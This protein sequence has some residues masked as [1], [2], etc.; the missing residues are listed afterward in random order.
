MSFR[1]VWLMGLAACI[2]GSAFAQEVT[3][4]QPAPAPANATPVS[5][6]PAAK[7]DEPVAATDPNPAKA[8]EEGKLDADKI[9]AAQKAGYQ[10]KNEN[11][12]TLLCRKELQTGSRVR[13]RTSCLTAREWDQL[14]KDTVQTMRTFERPKP[15]IGNH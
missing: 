11:G 3:P 7:A 1:S 8:L 6:A 10:L 14:Q 9:M 13:Y 5:A 12:Q 2:A 4:A 15:M